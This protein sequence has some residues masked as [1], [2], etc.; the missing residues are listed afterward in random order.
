LTSDV[1]IKYAILPADTQYNLPEQIEI[2]GVYITVTT[3][4]GAQRKVDILGSLGESAL[5]ALED[6]ISEEKNM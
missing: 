6:E 3:K 1:E 5:M 2:L 4:K